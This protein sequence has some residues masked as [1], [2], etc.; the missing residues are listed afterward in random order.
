MY[1]SKITL[2]SLPNVFF[3]HTYST[4]KYHFSFP[5]QNN[6][7]E[8]GIVEQGAITIQIES[9]GSF[10]VPEDSLIILTHNH[11]IE[12]YRMETGTHSHSTVGIK[13]DFTCEAL[14]NNQAYDYC[15]LRFSQSIQDDFT[16][17]LPLFIKLDDN[18]RNAAILIKKIIKEFSL[19]ELHSKLYCSGLYLELITELSRLCCYDILLGQTAK[20][21]PG[22]IYYSRKIMDYITANYHRTITLAEVGEFFGKTPN[23]LNGIFKTVTGK[24]IMEYSNQ[25]RI[26]KVKELLNGHMT[27]KQAGESVG[28]N[29]ESYISRLF[30]KTTGLSAKEYKMLKY[31]E[32]NTP[33]IN[34]KDEY[35]IN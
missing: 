15:K 9:V 24:T 14:N 1:Y 21:S 35:K 7:L 13:V 34:R 16:C 31:K 28:I 33:A 30:K 12:T 19:S 32:M 29:D 11:P 18:S 17:V 2:R 8:I 3:A 6:F 4:D 27:L 25:V 23:Y 22:S 20:S 5:A 26:N 10:H